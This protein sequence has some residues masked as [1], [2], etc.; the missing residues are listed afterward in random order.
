MKQDVKQGQNN[1]PVRFMLKLIFA[2]VFLFLSILFVMSV[3]HSITFNEADKVVF[4]P[5]K[6]W[7]VIRAAVVF[8]VLMGLKFTGLSI[9]RRM[10]YAI[11]VLYFLFHICLVFVLSLNPASDQYYMTWIA[12]DMLKGDYSQFKPY[13]YMDLF[14]FQYNFVRYVK[15]VFTV[16]GTDNYYALQILNVVYLWLI[17][18]L[19][20][21][22]TRFLFGREQYG[23]GVVLMLFFPLSLFVTYIYGTLLSLA[24]SLASAFFLMKFLNREGR[25][26]LNFILVVMLNTLSIL[27]KNNA[28]IFTMAEIC[29][30]V[31]FAVKRANRRDA[32]LNTLLITAVIMAYVVSL[33]AVNRDLSRYTEA[34]KVGTP[35]ISWIA[36]GL[37]T[38]G[39]AEG[40]HNF[41]NRDVYWDNGCD[42][43]RA[44][45]L[46][47]ASIKESVSAFLA[48]PKYCVKFFYKKICSE[49]MNPSFEAFHL[50]ERSLVKNP[51][52]AVEY[53]VPA[54]WFFH[55]SQGMTLDATHSVLNEYLRIYE[56]AMIAGAILYL[57]IRRLEAKDCLFAVVFIGGFLFHIFWEA[58]CQYMLPYFIMIV[59][60]GVMGLKDAMGIIADKAGLQRCSLFG[61]RQKENGNHL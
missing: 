39:P 29:I 20:V 2:F 47:R 53:T 28:L 36:M 45:E 13:G 32:L 58:A 19:I 60:Y 42:T 59:P 15:L 49:W 27:A 4:L 54:R 5:Q 52:S 6:W 9:S 18:W 7:G 61:G 17:I 43:E 41:Y 16:L 12:S 44:A 14:P 37:Q 48:D 46:S 1:W 31:L 22:N 57:I 30:M 50:I 38:G 3:T 23:V 11:S 34:D 24:L 56:F 51:N 33:A 26:W 40:W 55:R 25:L 10:F 8:C 21:K 35:K